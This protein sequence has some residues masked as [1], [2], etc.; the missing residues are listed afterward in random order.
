MLPRRC[1]VLRVLP[2]DFGHV[3]IFA[4][5]LLVGLHTFDQ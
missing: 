2:P 5:R 1:L 4:L 3:R